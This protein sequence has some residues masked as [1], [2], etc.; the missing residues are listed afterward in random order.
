M[1]SA[2][3]ATSPRAD[4]VIFWDRSPRAIA[5]ATWEID[6]TWWVRLEAIVLTESVR[7]FQVPATPR[8]SA[9]PPS[10]PSVPTSRAT[11]V[12]SSANDDSWSTIVFTVRPIRRNSPRRGRPSISSAMCWDRSP[13]ATATMT[14]EI[15]VSGR[16]RSSISELTERTLS[17]QAPSRPSSS[18]RSVSRPSR[19]TIRLIR[20]TSRFCRSCSDTT[21]LNASATSPAAPLRRGSR[22]LRSPRRTRRSAS[23]SSPSRAVSSGTP[24]LASLAAVML[25]SLAVQ[26]FRRASSYSSLARPGQCERRLCAS[27][28]RQE[29]MQACQWRP[30]PGPRPPRVVCPARP[31]AQR[32]AYPRRGP[33]T[34]PLGARGGR[35]GRP[36]QRGA[37]ADHRALH[38]R[39][40]ARQ[41]RAGHR[42]QRR[43]DRA[44]RHGHRLRARPGRAARGRPAQRDRG[45]RRGR[46]AGPRPAARRPLRQPLGHRARGHRQGRVVP[47][48]AASGP[49]QTRSM[50]PVRPTRPRP[51]PPASARSP[52]CCRS[53]PSGRPTRRWPT[54]PPTC[55]PGS[56]G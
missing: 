7:S 23:A 41:H 36:A 34:R 1:V 38:Q 24:T 25:S 31:A 19:P 39:R 32:P 56:P 15:S 26:S 11:R 55:W 17:A 29:R 44:D 13:S 46:R 16:P 18:S 47:A 4:T 54:S 3:S 40:G 51:A 52:R 21:S 20:R 28:R 2:S 6:R 43:P 5:V 27:A 48:G 9:W 33:R 37:A 22:T 14:R 49:E 30:G 12:T 8:T 45:H 10:S 35:A 42:G 50:V 53:T